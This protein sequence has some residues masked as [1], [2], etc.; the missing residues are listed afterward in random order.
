MNLGCLS[1]G[2]FSMVVAGADVR[3]A[4][5]VEYILVKIGGSLLGVVGSV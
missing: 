3:L 5:S 4:L 2:R 1:I